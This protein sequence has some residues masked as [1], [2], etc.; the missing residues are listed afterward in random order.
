MS[1]LQRLFLLGAGGHA[2]MVIESARST[3]RFEI[4]ACLG[5]VQCNG[6]LLGVPLMTETDELL[7]SFAESEVYGFVAVGDNGLR[8]KLSE[9]LDGFGIEQ[10]T[11]V[12]A[13]SIVSPSARLGRGTVLMPGTMV[14]ADAQIGSGCILNTGCSV[15]HDC[16][17]G[18]FVHV[19]PGCH[20]AGNV[21]AADGVFLGIGS[22]VVPDLCLGEWSTVGAGAVVVRD[23][24][25]REV[26]V[27]C[28]ARAKTFKSA[29]LAS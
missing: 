11:I 15:D 21:R 12:A 29:R 22:V 20:L 14:G 13:S 9:K 28:P 19:A 1:C 6:Q 27:G 24:P 26:W 16:L 2:K 4:I 23:I 5:S 17:L 3:T 8:K 7:Q 18:D 10:T 25:G